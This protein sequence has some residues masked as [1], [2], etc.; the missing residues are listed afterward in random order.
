MF[1][2]KLGELLEERARLREYIDSLIEL[3]RREFHESVETPSEVRFN[4]ITKQ[5]NQKK[6]EL[7]DLKIKLMQ[8]NLKTK[9]PNL[10]EANNIVE[11]NLLITDIMAEM[12]DLRSLLGDRCS[13]NEGVRPQLSQKQLREKIAELFREKVILDVLRKKTNWTT[14]VE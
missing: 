7:R 12:Q 6:K 8:F 5:I 11:V 4:E 10:N 1:V 3:R 2:I 14:E 13:P 9:I